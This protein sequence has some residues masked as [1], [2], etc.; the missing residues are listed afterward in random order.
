MLLLVGL[1]SPKV[2]Y[3]E[4]DAQSL[5]TEGTVQVNDP[6]VTTIVDPENPEK[7]INPGESPSTKGSLRIDYVSS[8]EFGKVKLKKTDRNYHSLASVLKEESLTRGHFLQVTD[9]RDKNTGWVLQ[10]KQEEQFKTVDYDE[11]TGAVLSF[12]K[13]WANSTSTS[14]APTVT[15]DAIAITNI[16]EVYDVARASKDSGMGVWS[17][18]FGASKDNK[19]NQPNTLTKAKNETNTTQNSKLA[20]EKTKSNDAKN[21]ESADIS[22]N[23]LMENSAVILNIPD[24]TKVLPKEYQ[25]KITWILG[26]LP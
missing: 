26:E 20:D 3:A 7:P 2:S 10:V 1:S 25:T 4:G 8:L 22:L 16:G 11:L 17:I 19:N 5:A 6:G 18:S 12:D 14:G 13:G 9:F 23:N 21:S 24:A 15:R